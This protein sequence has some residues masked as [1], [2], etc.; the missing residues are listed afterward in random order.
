MAWTGDPKNPVPN[1]GNVKSDLSETIAQQPVNLS[2][3]LTD[4]NRA[5]EVR[6]DTDKQK[7]IQ[8]LFLIQM[9]LL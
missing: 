3:K 9:K 4:I 2:E 8:L 1:I 7:T 5:H 6:R